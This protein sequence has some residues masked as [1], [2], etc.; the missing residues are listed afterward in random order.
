MIQKSLHL[1]ARDSK[2]LHLRARDSKITT[3]Q[4]PRFKNHYISEP[5]IQKL[6]HLRARD[7]KIT[8]SQAR[9]QK[10]LHLRARD[11]KINTSQSPR[12]K[13]NYISEPAIQKL[14]HLRAPD[15][16]NFGKL[17]H[18]LILCLVDYLDWRWRNRGI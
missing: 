13:N 17:R 5:A 7:S 3:S 15:S 9:I 11:S 10:L 16:K 4:S 6:I 1:R 8:T 2:L 12:F 14:L 18:V